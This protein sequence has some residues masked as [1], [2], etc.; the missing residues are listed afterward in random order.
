MVLHP[1]QQFFGN[2]FNIFIIALL[3]F[4]LLLLLMTSFDSDSMHDN[5]RALQSYL[6]RKYPS[7]LQLEPSNG[8][9]SLT[10]NDIHT[11]QSMV[12]KKPHNSEGAEIVRMNAL[13][14]QRLE[15]SW[16]QVLQLKK[17]K[18]LLEIRIAESELKA[19]NMKRTF[20]SESEYE[21]PKDHSSV[22]SS[23]NPVMNGQ[24]S[25]PVSENINQNRRV[26][27]QDKPCDD[28]PKGLDSEKPLQKHAPL[29]LSKP[30]SSKSHLIS[31]PMETASSASDTLPQTTSVP[32]P[33]VP[34]HV[35][36]I[37]IPQL[38]TNTFVSSSLPPNLLANPSADQ[39][40]NRQL[41]EA[42]QSKEI[43]K[44]QL[45]LTSPPKPSSVPVLQNA[46]QISS[47]ITA[48]EML[49][50]HQLSGNAIFRSK[51]VPSTSIAHGIPQLNSKH[52]NVTRWLQQATQQH[53]QMSL[54]HD[55]LR[56]TLHQQSPPK[57]QKMVCYYDLDRLWPNKYTCL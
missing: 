25:S 43:S 26:V 15:L 45:Y 11:Q 3:F 21:S 29:D 40:S 9:P 23:S 50:L 12:S 20:S 10:G 16:A 22:I 37:N 7:S 2:L 5:Q 6:K 51:V 24:P 42:V 48:A 34:Q 8:A 36:K 4:R 53:Q 52:Y 13:L 54:S 30:K 35:S 32:E 18:A 27:L 38:T 46:N 47:N 1:E 44:Q 33:P 39:L 41:G 31:K 49:R 56:N 28:Q 57:Q 19:H 17:E 55:D 14:K